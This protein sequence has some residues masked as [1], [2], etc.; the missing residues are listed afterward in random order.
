MIHIYTSS[1]HEFKDLYGLQLVT[2][3]RRERIH[4]YLRTEDKIRCLLAGLLLRQVCGITDD[5]QLTYG[6]NDKPYLKN[7]DIHFNISHSG[8]YVVLAAANCEVGVDIEKAIPCSDPLS[9]RYFTIQENEWMQQE[10]YCGVYNEAF[11]RLW[12]AKESVMKAS[13]LGFSLPPETFCLLPLD[14]SVHYIADKSWYLSWLSY[15][16]HIICCAIEGKPQEIKLI[17]MNSSDLLKGH[18]FIKKSIH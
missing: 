18:E 4:K 8:D 11:Y 13:G 3:A 12:T 6:E 5:S 9:A 2:K 1:I 7:S 17:E 15:D 14:S 10:G 16:G